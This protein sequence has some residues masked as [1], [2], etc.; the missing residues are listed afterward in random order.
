MNLINEPTDDQ[1]WKQMD[2]EQEYETVSLS[3]RAKAIRSNAL[4][5]CSNDSVQALGWLSMDIT[6]KE[7][8]IRDRD[9]TIK[10]LKECIKILERK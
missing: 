3:D 9:D 2:E 7:L 8:T 1:W 4:K 5:D 6:L 10:H